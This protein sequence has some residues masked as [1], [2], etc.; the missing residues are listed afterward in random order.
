VFRKCYI[1]LGFEQYN[2]I[3]YKYNAMWYICTHMHA[4]QTYVMH[5]V[6]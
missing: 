5:A 4:T 6:V 1:K 2:I 3:Q